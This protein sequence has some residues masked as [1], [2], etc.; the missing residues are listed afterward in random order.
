MPNLSVTST[1]NPNSLKFTLD[2]GTFIESGM[3]SFASAREASGHE[4][5]E[6]L[7]GIAG[8]E[9][10]FILPQFL[11]VTKAPAADWDEIV[12]HIERAVYEALNAN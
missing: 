7:F 6:P 4:L 11:T 1:P 10:V 3:E 8:V 2:S 9:N 5:G 12:P